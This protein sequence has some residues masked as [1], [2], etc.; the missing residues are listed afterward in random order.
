MSARRGRRPGPK[1]PTLLIGPPIIPGDGGGE[2]RAAEAGIEHGGRSARTLGQWQLEATERGDHGERMRRRKGGGDDF[3][4][5]AYK[6]LGD[7]DTS[8]VRE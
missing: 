6:I 4:P 7:E 3:N 8:T 2:G 1:T 5:R